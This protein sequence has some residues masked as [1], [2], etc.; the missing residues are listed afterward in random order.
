[1]LGATL[2]DAGVTLR[3]QLDDSVPAV[4][5]QLVPLEQV[6]VNLIGNARDALVSRPA[7]HPRL[8]TVTAAAEGDG[9]LITIAD[10]AGGIPDA[11]MA[12]LFQPFVTT[13]GEDHGTGLGL[14]LCQGLVQHMGGTI[15]G[16]NEGG[17]AVFR[18]RLPAAPA[19]APQAA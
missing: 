8:V 4:L 7:G 3:V 9:V 12:R 13:K 16:S 2:R 5:G 6:L 14:S 15:D 10:N 17:G 11:V 1:M 19:L 18:I